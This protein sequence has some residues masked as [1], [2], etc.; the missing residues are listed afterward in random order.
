MP[1]SS[2]LLQQVSHRRQND[3]L[4]SPLLKHLV[5]GGQGT[6]PFNRLQ[7]VMLTNY[8]ML[9]FCSECVHVRPLP[10]GG[11][12]AADVDVPAAVPRRAQE[13]PGATR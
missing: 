10:P 3:P 13:Q 6:L 2:L 1:A 8:V 12:G 7:Y 9:R 11:I 4:P 5:V